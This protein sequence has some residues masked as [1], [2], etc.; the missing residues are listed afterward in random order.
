PTYGGGLRDAYVA[1]LDP[2]GS[3][4]DYS[5]YLGGSDYDY[6][7][8][9]AV[10]AAGRTYLAGVTYSSDFPA[11]PGAVQPVFGGATDAFVVEVLPA[12]TRATAE[13]RQVSCAEMGRTPLPDRP[14][15]TFSVKLLVTVTL[16]YT[17]VGPTGVPF[18]TFESSYTFVKTVQLRAPEGTTIRCEALPSS[19]V[20]SVLLVDRQLYTAVSLCLS[21]EAVAA[22]RLLLPAPGACVAGECRCAPCPPTAG[23]GQTEG[24]DSGAGEVVCVA[25][26]L[27]VDAC[28]Q[29]ELLEFAVTLP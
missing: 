6:G 9:V 23:S 25:T 26:T 10:D 27:V 13:I 4:L 8:A 2:G 19:A 17:L 12:G 18:E 28:V 1:R 5:S 3:S 14:P 7:T 15:G 29:S 21:S 16:A 20:V 24:E 22:V 11:T